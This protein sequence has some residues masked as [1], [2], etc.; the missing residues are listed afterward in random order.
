MSDWI[1][2]M[3]LQSV[4]MNATP[5][6]RYLNILPLIQKEGVGRLNIPQPQPT[7]LWFEGNSALA[8]LLFSFQAKQKKL[9]KTKA[10][11]AIDKRSLLIIVDSQTQKQV[12][13][14]M[15]RGTMER[16]FACIVVTDAP[17]QLNNPHLAEQLSVHCALFISKE[18][19]DRA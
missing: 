19:I 8:E 16:G 2:I 15:S 3:Q 7:F 10:K 17:P 5:E 18:R 11:D 6:N 1:N 4:P 9:R 13:I 14:F 12:F